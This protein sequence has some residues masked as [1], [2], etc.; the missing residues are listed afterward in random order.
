MAGPLAGIRVIDLTTI[1]MGPYATQI[2]GDM[3]AD[4][5][6]VESPSGD[7]FRDVAP[8]RHAGMGAAFLNTNRNK[9]SIA[10]NLEREE[11]RQIMLKLLATADVFVYTLRP[12]SLA[13]FGLDYASLRERNPRLIHCGAYG[14]SEGGPYA[15]R[16]AYDDIIQAMSGT[17]S[18]EGRNNP[19]GPKFVNTIVADKVAGLSAAY[20]I[21][22]ALY[23]RERSGVGQAIEVPMF[24]N[25]VSFMMIEHLAGETFVPALGGMGYDR[26]LSPHRRP[27]R[28]KDGYIG[29][30]PYSTA[31]WKRFFEI[32]GKPEYAADARFANH[33]ARS[34]HIDQLYGILAEILRERTTEE[35]MRLLEAA[36]IPMSP[37]LAPEELLEDPHLRALDFFYRDVHPSEG[38]IRTVSIPVGFSRTPGAIERLAPRLDE[39]REEIL[40]ELG[41]K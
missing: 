18:L 35:W 26:V 29:L 12:R 24:E 31:H 28:T 11:D 5:I 17:A 8:F 9:R 34:K 33:A 41:L 32:A 14:F 27:Y 10:L 16:P 15:G 30:M 37:I 20:A 6:K 23:E 25:L 4:V 7:I 2:L 39:N 38:E 3:G 13:R 21:G 40:K 22:L 1:V 36:D 19:G